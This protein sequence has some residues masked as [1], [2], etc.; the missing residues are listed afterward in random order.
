[1]WR[2]SK[3]PRVLAGIGLPLRAM[4][5]MARHPEERGPLLL[6]LSLLIGGTLFY[7]LWEDWSVVDSLYFCAMSLATVGY[8]DLVP[9]TEVGKVFTV[10]YVLGGIGTLV[11]FFTSLTAKVLRLQAERRR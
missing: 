1:M 3:R 11:A 7:T 5:D 9:E 8:G 2:M 4:I 6:V 10:V